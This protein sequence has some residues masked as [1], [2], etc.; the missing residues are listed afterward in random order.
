MRQ[1]F[2]PACLCVMTFSNTTGFDLPIEK[3]A[4]APRFDKRVLLRGTTS[5][6]D[7]RSTD[8]STRD[9]FIAE[10]PEPSDKA[11]SESD[12]KAVSKSETTVA[13]VPRDLIA[14]NEAPTE[15]PP[16]PAP[17][18]EPEKI[19]L[20]PVAKPVVNRSRQEVCDSLAQAAQSNNLPVPFFIRLLF[21]ESGFKPDVV[22]SAG[23]EGIAQF[24]PET[25]ASEGLHNP[26]DPLQAIPASARFLRK[27]FVQF[28]NLGL[29]AAAY[30][31]GPKR[32]HDWLA[33]KGKGRLPEETQGYVK[34]VTG[35]PAETWRVASAGGTAL[36]VPRRAPCQD[37]VPP[38]P[39]TAHVVTAAKSTHVKTMPK[40]VAANT[41][42]AVTAKAVPGKTS[43]V[44]AP[45]SHKLPI[46]Q[47][48]ARKHKAAHK[49][50]TIAQR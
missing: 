15:A 5:D 14:P 3:F 42:K 4:D 19:P 38:V 27:L 8:G 11:I 41:A 12:S 17:A 10:D 24:M 2:V 22:S 23:A 26:F 13:E 36:S 45:A 16:A 44:K 25:S 6:G 21:Q 35:R 7:D 39:P 49:N 31:A 20:P 40:Q 28:G 30:N 18:L 34:T 48:A 37:I 1:L 47:F 32:V 33:S 46:Q 9:D 43:T 50:Q 29:A